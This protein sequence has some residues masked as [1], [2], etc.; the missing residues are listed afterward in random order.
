[1]AEAEEE[2]CLLLASGLP[3]VCYLSSPPPHFLHDAPEYD[4]KNL[5]G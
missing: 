4:K 2:R 1:M 5:S 3:T